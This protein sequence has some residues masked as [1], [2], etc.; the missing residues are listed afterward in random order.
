MNLIGLAELAE[1]YGVS[2]N[3]ANTWARRHSFPKPVASLKMGPVWDRDEVLKYRPLESNHRQTVEICCPHCGGMLGPMFQVH[4]IPHGIVAR[5][6]CG[7][8]EQTAQISLCTGDFD[9]GLFA[10][11]IKEDA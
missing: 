9:T 1:L 4:P 5:S 3:T 7:G 11:V 10:H 6:V 2:K 8:C